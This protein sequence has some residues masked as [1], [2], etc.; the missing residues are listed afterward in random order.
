MKLQ[1]WGRGSHSFPGTSQAAKLVPW[2][3]VGVQRES[4][5]SDPVG[6]WKTG[7]LILGTLSNPCSVDII[8]CFLYFGFM[9]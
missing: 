8:L 2:S 7:I 3:E 9:I 6:S 1:N 4:E 5:Q